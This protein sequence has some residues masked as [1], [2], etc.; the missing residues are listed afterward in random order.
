MLKDWLVYVKEIGGTTIMIFTGEY[1]LFSRSFSILYLVIV[2]FL[3][4]LNFREFWTY[5]FLLVH[6]SQ[7]VNR[8][9]YQ[10]TVS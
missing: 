9:K 5:F 2:D 7:F 10:I 8:N 1:D 4:L 3:F 6:I